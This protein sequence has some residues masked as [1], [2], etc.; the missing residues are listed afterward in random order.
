MPPLSRPTLDPKRGPKRGLDAEGSWSA[1][2]DFLEPKRVVKTA[3]KEGEENQ[4]SS[5]RAQGEL[6]ESSRRDQAAARGGVGKGF[7]PLEPK[8]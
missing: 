5:G 7:P 4:G 1:L 3:P 8:D 2:E 6:R